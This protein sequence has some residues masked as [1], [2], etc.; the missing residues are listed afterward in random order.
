MEDDCAKYAPYDKNNAISK[1]GELSYRLT[2][3]IPALHLLAAFLVAVGTLVIPQGNNSNDRQLVIDMDVP[4]DL[5]QSPTYA[6]VLTAQ[7]IFQGVV[8]Y[9]YSMF[10]T[11]LL[12][13]VSANNYA[14]MNFPCSRLPRLIFCSRVIRS[15]RFFRS[16]H[17][18][19][20]FRINRS[21]RYIRS[22]RS[23]CSP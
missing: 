15:S 10:S 18:D 14:R 9:T 13:L 17:V 20:S 3:I 23:I 12:M 21:S 11:I 5:N 8:G 16:S 19:R 22:S 2:S 7:F 6:L 1:T 4:F